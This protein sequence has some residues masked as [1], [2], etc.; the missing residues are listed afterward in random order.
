MVSGMLTGK[1]PRCTIDGADAGRC[2]PGSQPSK[3]FFPGGTRPS[4]GATGRLSLSPA[5]PRHTPQQWSS[6][7]SPSSVRQ[8]SPCGDRRERRDDP[9]DLPVCRRH[10]PTRVRPPHRSG[11]RRPVP[12]RRCGQPHDWGRCGGSGGLASCCRRGGGGTG[13]ACFVLRRAA[14]VASPCRHGDRGGGG[15]RRRPA[16]TT[17]RRPHGRG[18]AGAPPRR[19]DRAGTEPRRRVADRRGVAPALVG[20]GGPTAPDRW[21]PVP[22]GPRRGPPALRR[23]GGGRCDGCVCGAG[24]RRETKK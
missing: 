6:L 24:Q 15:W 1:T 20:R 8:R 21:R 18:C 22:C 5:G 16:A 4:T 13:Q 17:G 23:A 12:P 9:L 11:V 2:P 7:C 10:C 14:P 3:C 19:G